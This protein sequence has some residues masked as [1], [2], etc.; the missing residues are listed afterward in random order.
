MSNVQKTVKTGN[1]TFASSAPLVLITGPCQLE[2]ADHALMI[3]RTMAEA[4]AAS[5]AGYVFK[6]SFDKA[7]RTSLS[8]KRGLGIDKGLEVLARVKA[9]IGCPVLTDIHSEA[10]CGPVAEVCD[11]LQIPAILCRQTDQLL[12][13]GETKA[14]VNI[15]K[16]HFIA[17]L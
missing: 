4:C 1:V 7:N 13:A 5:G 6:G 3:A 17:R 12:A 10:Q 2:S 14:T 11:I 8:G 16:G 15:K 9:E